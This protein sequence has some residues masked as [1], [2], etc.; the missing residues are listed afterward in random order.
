[1][2]EAAG[3]RVS[4]TDLVLDLGAVRTQAAAQH[5]E[6][7]ARAAL[8]WARRQPWRSVTLAC[9]AFPA[10]ISGLPYR[11]A[12]PV[13]RWDAV[14]WARITGGL[15]GGQDAGIGYGDYAV[16]SP[17]LAAGRAPSPNL[18][19][20]GKRHWHVYRYPKA[21]KG[22]MS[23]FYDLCQ[24]VVASGHWPARGG[25][26][27]WGDEQIGRCA[28]HHRTPGNATVW[29]AIG[30]SHHLAVV[31]GRLAALGEP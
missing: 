16:G 31:T 23:T 4:D 20:T 28:R 18:R 9:G 19:Y 5:A 7:T 2:L 6:R 11:T 21:D 17:E 30:T 29:R 12:T 25:E 22:D 1:M 24:D 14:L 13:P 27:S 3:L 26:F 10:S 8:A 15:L